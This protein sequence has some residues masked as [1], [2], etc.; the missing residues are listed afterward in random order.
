MIYSF[1]TDNSKIM[2][3]LNLRDLTEME[4]VVKYL[5]LPTRLYQKNEVNFK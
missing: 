5:Y 4:M 3:I 2:A 1:L